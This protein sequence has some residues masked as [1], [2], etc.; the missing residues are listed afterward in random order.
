MLIKRMLKL[1]KNLFTEKRRQKIW[2]NNK[3]E[4]W[5]GG[6][7]HMINILNVSRA[8]LTIPICAK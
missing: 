1:P 4:M 8:L 3:R 6:Y 5:I 2:M 7:L